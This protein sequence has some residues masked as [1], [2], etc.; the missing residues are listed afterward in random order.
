MPPADIQDLRLADLEAWCAEAGEPPF[1]ARQVLTWVHRKGAPGFAAMTD[2]SRRLR[3]RLGAAF[4][5]GRLTP[6]AVADARDGTRKLLF[7]LDGEGGRSA[8]IESVLIPQVE[9]AGGARDRLT[10]CISS[11]AGCGMGCGFCATARLG[12][13][14][15]LRPAEI[16]GQVHAGAALAAPKALTNIVLMGMGEP[17]A[18]YDAVATAC[19]LLTADW[20]YAISPRRI[21]VSTV[22]LA[23]LIPRFIAETRVNLA[24]SLH[25]PTDAQRERIV[26]VN[27]RY[28]LADLLAACRAV[29]LPRRQ[30]ITFEYVMLAGEN[31]ADQDARALVRLLHGLRAKVNLIPWNAFPGAAFT[32]SPRAQVQRFQALLHAQGINAT[33]RESR[34][35]DIQAAC[36]QLATAA[37]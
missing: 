29:P 16:V 15:N 26:P 8:A 24:V 10:L 20:G 13:V 33:I 27:R 1:R 4:R 12:L 11:Q 7:Q 36:G 35:Q 14:R 23:P 32:P 6:S 34:G 22:G 19:E 18:N 31:D 28:P 5:L 17:L 37:A 9:R 21:T 2:V 30:R 3:E 25:A